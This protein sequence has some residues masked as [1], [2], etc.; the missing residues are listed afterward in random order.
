ML[1]PFKASSDLNKQKITT[2][3]KKPHVRSITKYLKK[4]L[5]KNLN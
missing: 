2:K 1:L 3:N 5:K 4:Y